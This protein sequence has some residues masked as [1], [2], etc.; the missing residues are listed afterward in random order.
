LLRRSGDVHIGKCDVPAFDSPIACDEVLNFLLAG[1][2][3]RFLSNSVSTISSTFDVMVDGAVVHAVLNLRMTRSPSSPGSCEDD[4][5]I[6]HE[7]DLPVYLPR[8]DSDSAKARIECVYDHAAP[9]HV[10]I[11][12]DMWIEDGSA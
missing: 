12:I 2:G 9:R 6:L 5:K 11:E 1:R 3:H 7:I 8:Q 4:R 10:A